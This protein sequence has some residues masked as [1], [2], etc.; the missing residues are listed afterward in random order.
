V[1]LYVDG[2]LACRATTLLPARPM[3][4]VLSGNNS[5]Q[6]IDIVDIGIRWE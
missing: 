4:L 2:A 6:A 1:S 3:V 5:T